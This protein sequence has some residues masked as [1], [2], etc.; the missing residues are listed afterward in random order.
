[1][2]TAAYSSGTPALGVGPGNVPV[3]I[4]RTADVTC[5]IGK[6]VDGKSFDYGTVCSSEQAVV[7]EDVLRDQV[8]TRLLAEK[9]YFCNEEQKQSLR[10]ILLTPRWTVNPKCVGQSPTRIAKLAGFEVP[11]DTRILVAEVNQGREGRSR[12][13][14]RNFRPCWRCTS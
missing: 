7:A 10:Q 13:R 1:M 5:A 3:L 6:I 11:A 4:E 12:S 8:I 2:V 9:A 14:L